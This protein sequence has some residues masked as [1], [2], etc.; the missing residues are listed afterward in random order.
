VPW[1]VQYEV[2]ELASFVEEDP[3]PVVAFYGGEPLL[4][5]EFIVD[6]MEALPRA[7]F[8]M[9]TNG[10]LINALEPHY[11]G[12]FDT[13][14]LSIDGVRELTD[15]YRGKGV[16][17]RVIEAAKWLRRHGYKGD[18]IARMTVTE[19]SDIYRD[20]TH[21]LSL[22]L[23]DHVHW[24]L[25]VVWSNRWRDFR[26]WSI[27]SYKPGISKLVSLWLRRAEKGEILGIA[28]F[29]AIAYSALSGTPLLSPPCG[30][31]QDSVAILTDGRIIACPIAVYEGWA[32]MG[33]LGHSS[34]RDLKRIGIRDPCLRCEYYRYCGGRCLYAYK[35]K[36][37]GEAGF[38]E[39][40]DLTKHFLQEVL[41]ATVKLRGLI[42]EGT[43]RLEELKYPSFNNTVEI[44]P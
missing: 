7:K 19:D 32:N 40:C 20:V 8:V 33:K 37:W 39:I 26:K 25:D 31:G 11:W 30:A 41:E 18:L 34:L 23:F 14:L 29:K 24:Q 2:E 10:L 12:K 36:L 21:L 5:P 22:G 44:I 1:V 4:N 42:S 28:P 27:Q 9:Q 17:D 15:K 35:E 13:V 16:Y 6:V 38:R 3:E 43:I